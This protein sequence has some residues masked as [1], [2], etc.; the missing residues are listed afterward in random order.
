[1]SSS[2][3]EARA[4]ALLQAGRL[5]EAEAALRAILARNPESP[6]ALHLLGLAMFQSGRHAEAVALLDRSLERDAS[7]PMFL[8]NAAAVHHALGLAALARGDTPRAEASFRRALAAA[9][10][11]A[12][13][14][15]NLGVTV[16]RDGRLDEAQRAFEAALAIDPRNADAHNNLGLVHQRR[17]VTDAAIAAYRRAV[18]ARPGF[19]E[20]MLNW[21]NALKDAGDLEGA[22]E[23]YARAVEHA[24]QLAQA[25]VNAGSIALLTARP[26]EARRA[27]ERALSLGDSAD[28]RFGLAQ[29]AL[30]D[31]DFAAAWDGYEARFATAPPQAQRRDLALPPLQ[32]H[33]L[34]AGHRVAVWKEQGVG[35]QVL[36]S[37]LLPELAAAGTRAVVEVDARLASIYRRSLPAIGFTTPEDAERDFAACTRQVALG[38]LARFLRRDTASFARQ[39]RA[40]WSADPQRVAKIR[41]RLG[42]GAWIA[43]SWRSLQRG[44]RRSLGERKSVP[45]ERFA[46]I[47]QA[48]GARLLDLQY[49]DVAGERADF[50]ARHP[51][52]LE[53]L[54]DLDTYNDFEGVAAAIAACGRVV[55]ASN[56]TAHFA[57]ALG[58]PTRLV[59]GG[60]WPPFHYWTPGA[61]G[62]SL[63]YP[64]VEVAGDP[65]K[66]L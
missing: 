4:F 1:M 58:V 20:A 40:L 64:S 15:A 44:E 2:T 38:S 14:L 50:A 21:G 34:G 63:W 3:P 10:R 29:A 9:P 49:G 23:R 53:R 60:G 35:D 54:E 56:V 37:T 24:P 62:R 65:E 30:R 5:A 6:D 48:A 55:T 39:P 41:E 22:A 33:E 8:K 51:G 7:N 19:A 25:W 26:G 57:G 16:L 52:V 36:F 46:R 27:Y 59:F 11:D 18:D 31:H 47:A 17:G 13:A 66:G 28:A 61:D 32:P 43:I 45:L 42:S 12:N